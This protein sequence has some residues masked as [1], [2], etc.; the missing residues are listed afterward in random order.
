MT[1]S[2]IVDDYGNGKCPAL[3]D[4]QCRIYDG[5]PLTCRTVPLHYSRQQS[6]LHS[7]IDQFTATPGYECNTTTSPVIL[8]GNSITSPDLRAYRT[9]AIEIARQDRKWKEHMLSLIDNPDTADR[10]GLPTY[11]AIVNNTDNGY[12]TLLPT[13]VG[14]RVAEYFG[15]ISAVKLRNLCDMQVAL[16]KAETAHLPADNDLSD[17][18]PLY[19][20]GAAGRGRLGSMIGMPVQR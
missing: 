10:A 15:L 16:I 12:A 11:D 3:Q 20:A 6:V 5:R 2:A 7:Y 18:L 17:L 8:N 14:W 4:N 19:E 1:I 9:R 13:I